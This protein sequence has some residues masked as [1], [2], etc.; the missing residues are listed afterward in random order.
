MDAAELTA[1]YQRWLLEVWGAGRYEVDDELIRVDLVDHNRYERQPEGRAG[2]V[3]SGVSCRGRTV[4]RG[5]ASSGRAEHACPAWTATSAVA[6][7]ARSAPERMAPPPVA[8][9][10]LI[11]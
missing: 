7:A 4:R 2:D 5:L 11:R 3:S 1:M 6:D 10:Q 8:A 9:P